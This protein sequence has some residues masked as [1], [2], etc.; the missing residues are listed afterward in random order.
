MADNLSDILGNYENQSIEELGNSLL[1]RQSDQREAQRKSDKK[2]AKIG[3]ALAVLGVGQKI[4][5][6][7]YG[8]R[9]DELD[10]RE[11]FLLSNQDSQVKELQMVGR[12]VENMPD[13]AFHEKYKDKTTKEKTK[14]YLEDGKG[15]GLF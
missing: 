5:K 15:Q 13:M 3:Q 7:A 12:I 11:S 1:Q 8:K 14:L 10:A 4:F 9:K 2:S 6:N